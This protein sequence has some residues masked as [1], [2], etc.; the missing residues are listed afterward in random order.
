MPRFITCSILLAWLFWL[1]P[2]T[3]TLAIHLKTR[4][5]D[6]L[7][8][9]DTKAVSPRTAAREGRQ[10]LLVQ[11]SRALTT[12]EFQRLASG[13]ARILGYVPDQAYVISTPAEFEWEPFPLRHQA[14]ITA[15]DKWSPL[16]DIP[17]ALADGVAEP[18]PVFYLALFHEDVEVTAARELALG[19]ALE[20]REHPNLMPN[21][22]LVQGPEA[23][24]R[25]LSEFDE[26]AYILPASEDLAMG[27]P[28]VPCENGMVGEYPLSPLAAA[29]A[30]GSGW[31]ANRRAP[32]TVTTT[33]G[34]MSARLESSAAR[35]E[36]ERALAEWAR[37]VRIDFRAGTSAVATRNLHFLFGIRHHGDSFPFTGASGVIA[38]AFF[39][40]PPNPEPIAGDV[41]F[42]DDM[43]F[44]I[45]AD[46]DLFSVALHEIGH[47]L[48]LPHT[49]SGTTV[50]YPYYRRYT[51]LSAGDI[52]NIRQL[53][54][55]TDEATP[56]AL[57][58]NITPVNS[59]GLATVN[60]AGT[61]ENGTL[62]IRV[63]WA[64][65]RGG[66]GT[67]QAD[68]ARRWS[69]RN[70]PLS[71]G[72]NQFTLTAI[73]ATGTRASG[74]ISVNRAQAPSP[75]PAPAPTGVPELRVTSPPAT[76][77]AATVRLAGVAAAP[78]GIRRVTWATPAASGQAD[79]TLEW[80]IP[81]LPLQAGSNSV[82]LRAEALDGATATVTLTIVRTVASDRT[83]PL[84][85]I[86]S[87]N[88]PSVGTSNS[89]IVVTGAASDSGGLDAIT[90]QNGALSGIATGTNSWRAEIPLLPGFNTVIIRAR[91][92]ANN[93]AWR[94]LTVA[95]R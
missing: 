20:V 12:E 23:V 67:V 89:S 64:N 60:L 88:G 66:S 65:S 9:A 59:E 72:T 53:Y 38:H 50:M 21:H 77:T 68:T 47:A 45:G 49:D 71:L 61:V 85:A 92:L 57:R 84:I 10:R 93:T 6:P 75:A 5:F 30:T 58:I 36:I 39:P 76:T 87:P 80:T 18:A 44:R 42:N 29:A 41:H 54:L 24:I 90:W 73:D 82:T 40:A 55:S 17:V 81:A 27:W 62:P 22:L 3:D 91:D 8:T 78:Q 2:G 4:T 25:S 86:L 7:A 74:S 13:E 26:V 63:Q 48:G 16:L 35:G 69:I 37:V 43:P 83:A 11:F 34:A 52:A 32:V 31:A 56:A 46:T 95:R 79:G 1:E 28:V 51:A 15:A 19:L 94:S 14:P 33:W 70:V